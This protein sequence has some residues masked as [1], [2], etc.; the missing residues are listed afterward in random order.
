MYNRKLVRLTFF[1]CPAFFINT[2]DVYLK[3]CFDSSY[4]NELLRGAKT[5][6]RKASELIDKGTKTPYMW[7]NTEKNKMSNVANLRFQIEKEG[8]VI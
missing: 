7:T 4:R 3:D 6:L 8:K 1:S 2:A 5:L